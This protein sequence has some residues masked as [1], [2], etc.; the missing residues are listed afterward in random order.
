MLL[1]LRYTFRIW[2]VRR[3]GR[4]KDPN[5]TS[6]D[7]N[8][9]QIDLGVPQNLNENKKKQDGDRF[10]LL[11]DGSVPDSSLKNAAVLRANLQHVIFNLSMLQSFK[12][13]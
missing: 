11:E 3:S 6:S 5:V 9:Q 1:I 8:Q 13:C 10:N 4:R 2:F 12:I 7:N